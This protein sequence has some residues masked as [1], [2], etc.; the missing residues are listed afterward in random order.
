M[1]S[2]Q[3]K[4]TRFAPIVAVLA[5]AAL[6]GCAAKKNLW[7][8]PTTGLI[9]QYRMQEN[10]T[11]QYEIANTANQKMEVAGQS[12]DIQ[13]TDFCRFSLQSKGLGGSN[14]RLSV[15]L[16]SVYVGIGTPG[17]DLSPDLSSVN[18]KGFDMTLSVLGKEGDL[19]EAA[20]IEYSLGG[21]GTRNVA[22]TFQALFP[23]LAGRPLKIGDSWAT[24]DTISEK[25]SNGEIILTFD[26]INTLA[27]YETVD[28]F[29]CARITE[30]FTGSLKGQ[31]V[32][33]G[34]N[35]TYDGVIEGTGTSYFAYREG[36]LIKTTGTGAADA[37]IKG[38][39]PQEIT[40]PMKRSFQMETR[41]IK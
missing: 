34:M 22:T 18:G 28:G 12:V 29:E 37:T 20:S 36:L 5:I 10:Q 15:L 23:N 16:D 25:G 27:G 6:T 13:M 38:S 26:G 11:L 30:R 8:D 32:E 39:G 1:I 3:A 7:G 41:L 19:S 40:I 24:R 35:L 21:G 2:N 17:G 31:G 14:H 9:L 4:L 33:S